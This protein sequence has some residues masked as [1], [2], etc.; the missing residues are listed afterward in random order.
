MLV[1]SANDAANVLADYI[2]PNNI[3]A[4]VQM[5]N[6]CKEHWLR[7]YGIINPSGLDAEGQYTT[8]RDVA[9]FTLKALRNRF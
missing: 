2:C 3:G 6:E 8:A 1:A 7:E 4:F 9:K 5:M